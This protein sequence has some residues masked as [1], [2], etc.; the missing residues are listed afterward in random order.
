MDTKKLHGAV[1]TKE[2]QAQINPEIAK[3]LLLEGNKRFVNNNNLTRNHNNFVKTTSKS[4]YPFAV[5]ITC[6]DS[7]IEPAIIFDQGI[8]DIFVIRIA[9]NIINKDILG[10]IE[11][12]CYVAGAKL[13]LV[14]GHNSC[15]AVNAAVK[16]TKLEN[17]TPALEKIKLL[18]DKHNLNPNNYT[19]N[20]FADKL[21]EINALNSVLEIK[22]NSNILNTMYKNKEIDIAAC[23]YDVNTGIIRFL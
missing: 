17:L 11:Y 10:S 5:I 19:S 22:E 1:K 12:S 16:N 13:V 20:D 21:S 9:G 7:R 2:I 3:H 6:I 4:Q 23:M 15:G 18:A 8:G 14:M